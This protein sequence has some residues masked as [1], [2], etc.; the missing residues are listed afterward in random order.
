MFGGLIHENRGT[1]PQH[2]DNTF[3]YWRFVLIAQKTT[4]QRLEPI[5]PVNSII[6]Y[7]QSFGKQSKRKE[8]KG[9]KHKYYILWGKI[10]DN[11]PKN[12]GWQKYEA[13][14]GV[15][16]NQLKLKMALQIY[17]TSYLANTLYHRHSLFPKLKFSIKSKKPTVDADPTPDPT[18]STKKAV[19]PGQGFGSSPSPSSG[20][21][22]KK[23]KG[24]RERASIIRRS[25]VEKPAF[26]TKEEEAKA[27]EQR[28]NESAF[29]LAWL[30]LGGIIL[31]QGIVLA[32][33]GFSTNHY[34]TPFCSLLKVTHFFVV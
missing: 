21:N 24:K 1:K 18:S 31:V 19:V 32:A 34:Y 15:L 25:P 8:L 20:N 22:K 14:A 9:R 2:R 12:P 6:R 23:P 27:E 3:D 7:S 4:L 5:P 11:N 30:G 13:Q 29:L 33:S 28:K 16:L 10:R 26:L 17:T